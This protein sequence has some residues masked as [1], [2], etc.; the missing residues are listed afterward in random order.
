MKSSSVEI[1]ASKTE[2]FVVEGENFFLDTKLIFDPPLQDETFVQKVG[3]FIRRGFDPRVSLHR[4]MYAIWQNVIAM[5][6][7]GSPHPR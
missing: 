6:W 3:G 2:Y 7:P 5:T 4:S 1:Y